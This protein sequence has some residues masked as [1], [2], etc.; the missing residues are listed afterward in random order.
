MGILKRIKKSDADNKATEEKVEDV[1]SAPKATKKKASPSKAKVKSSK[2]TE[3][4]VILRPLVTEKTAVLASAGKYVF[5]VSTGANR[6]QVKTAI[7]EMFGVVPTSVN[8]QNVRGKRVRFGKR[9]GKRSDW[10]KAVV[11]LPKGQ[12]INVYEGV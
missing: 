5:V 6:I 4:N 1:A 2:V 8:I 10:K 11:S 3:P 12:K 7:K 9:R